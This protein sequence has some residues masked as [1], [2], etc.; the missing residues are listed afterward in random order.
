[1]THVECAPA[2]LDAFIQEFRNT[3]LPAL[4]EMGGLASAQLMVNRVTGRCLVISAWDDMSALT[5]SRQATAR[6]RA[7]VAAITH[8]QV[9]AIEEYQLVFS[10][11][12]DGDIRSLI[13]R[14][15]E[16]WNAKDREGWL[17]GM[18]LHRLA[19]TMPGG[20]RLTG[21][22][23]ADALWDS[24]QGPFPDNHLEIISIHADARGGVH[25]GH[26]TGTHTGVLR[27]PG[28]EIAPTGRR[29]EVDFCGVYEFEE[30]KIT[31][32]HL[33]FDQAEM[34][35]QLGITAGG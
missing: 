24:Y 18:D 33:Y 5:A 2:Y 7:D 9:R 27:G 20:V 25:E 31:S 10:S 30:G 6:L 29:A 34:L 22:D 32:Y 15:I 21:R 17:A 1:M 11:V 12:R 16:L 8:V 13:E 19:A 28:G 26:A 14:D 3:G 4:L 23:A 35:S